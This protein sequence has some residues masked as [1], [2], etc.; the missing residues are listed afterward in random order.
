MEYARIEPTAA[1]FRDY[2]RLEA[3][4]T[5][6]QAR[7]SAMPT[8][9]CARWARRRCGAHW[10]RRTRRANARCNRLLVPRDPHDDS[11]IFLEVRA[12]TG[13]DEAAIFS[14]DL[15]RMYQPLRRKKGLA[16]GNYQREPGRTWRLPRGDFRVV[17]RGV[18]RG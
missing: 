4:R 6:S 7:C 5:G 17:G 9:T 13:G 8:R 3:E 16:N 15:L 14:G 10:G 2:L 18:Y 11:N 1:A 12:G